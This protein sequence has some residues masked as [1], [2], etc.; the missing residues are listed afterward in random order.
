MI[1][2]G[3]VTVSDLQPVPR[4]VHED[5]ISPILDAV[6]KNIFLMKEIYIY[7]HADRSQSALI[8]NVIFDHK[9]I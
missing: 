8:F 3:S 7:F 9:D 1:G 5:A 4:L 2:E 6:F